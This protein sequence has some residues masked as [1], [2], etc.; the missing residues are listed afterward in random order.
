MLVIGEQ[1]IPLAK[2]G[3]GEIYFQAPQ[4]FPECSGH[5]ELIVDGKLRSWNVHLPNGA[6]PFERVTQTER[7]ENA[8]PSHVRSTPR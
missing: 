8:S 3:P 4:S 1:R 5:I 6:V 7:I 2:I